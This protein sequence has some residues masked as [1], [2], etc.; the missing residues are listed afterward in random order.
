M[1]KEKGLFGISENF[2]SIIT[3]PL[4]KQLGILFEIETVVSRMIKNSDVNRFKTASNQ[5]I[6]RERLADIS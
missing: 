6:S 4:S 1:M 5:V 3:W 2:Q